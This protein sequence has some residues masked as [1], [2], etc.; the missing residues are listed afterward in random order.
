[1]AARSLGTNAEHLLCRLGAAAARLRAMPSG[2]S[3][4]GGQRVDGLEASW[5][6]QRCEL[7]KFLLS[8]ANVDKI[9][10]NFA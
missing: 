4:P 10:Q 8:Y 6:M 9:M 1:M 3:L 7:C 5:G 2:L